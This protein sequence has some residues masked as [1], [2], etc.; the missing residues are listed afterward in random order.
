MDNN[1]QNRVIFS[2]RIARQIIQDGSFIC[3]LID[4]QPNNQNRDRTVFI[5]K[6]DDE[7]NKYLKDNF[8]II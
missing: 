5:F 4:I 1:Q 7:F 2:N 8:N 3:N 6:E